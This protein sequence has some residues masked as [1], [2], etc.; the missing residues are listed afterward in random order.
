M[1][2]RGFKGGIHPKEYKELTEHLAP[3]L[4]ESPEQVVIPVSQ[5]IG[6]PAIPVVEKKD[7]VQKGQVIAKA[8]GFVSVPIH[9]PVSGTVKKID[10]APHILGKPQTAIYI[11]NDGEYETVETDG[12][13]DW[14]NADPGDLKNRI[15]NAG[16]VGLGG[17]TFPTHVKLSPPEGKT[18]DTVILNGAECEPF[19]TADHRLMLDRP[20]EVIGGLRIFMKILGQK[21]G[22]IAIEENKPDAID[23]IQKAADRFPGIHVA[24]MKVKYPQ[25]AEKQLI[26][27]MTGRY[28]PSGGLPMDVGCVV[29]NVATASAA[30]RAVAL[31]QPLTGRF[32]TVTGDAIARPMNLEISVGTPLQTL[33]DFCGGLTEDVLKVIAGGP[34]MGIGIGDLEAPT[35]KG[36]GG[37]LCLSK[38]LVTALPENPCIRCGTC[39]RNCPMGLLPT[40]IAMA[41]KNE[42]IDLAEK[43]GAMDCIECGCCSFGCPSRI[44]L[45]QYI[46]VGKAEIIAA[47]KRSA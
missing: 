31:G 14:E 11:E 1:K 18:I 44:P 10:L 12:V 34:M 45:V 6:A 13:T 42:Q 26:R 22:I 43:F 9:S 27:A 25:G 39:V 17:A 30:Y 15:F 20:L 32:C 40:T 16:V 2:P 37:L 35:M 36:T 38:K 29:Q 5:H 8:G 33:I 47:R 19:L 41:V 28:I 21:Q 7:K 46:R 24:V 4:L 23:A 3:V